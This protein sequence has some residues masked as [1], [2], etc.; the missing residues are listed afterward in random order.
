MN[1]LLWTITTVATAISSCQIQHREKVNQ[2]LWV[3]LNLPYKNETIVNTPGDAHNNFTKL[4]DTL[5]Q[6]DTDSIYYY[7]FIKPG[8][9]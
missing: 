9:H 8:P 4:N 1:K 6:E 5:S 7:E 2:D 3:V